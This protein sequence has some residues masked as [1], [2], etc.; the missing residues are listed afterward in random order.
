MSLHTLANH[1]QTAGRG[2]DKVLVHMTPGEVNGL[3]SLAMAHG[4]SLS[5]NPETGLPEAGFLSKILPMVAGLALGPAGAGIAFGGMSSAV[6]AG[7]LVGGATAL[8]TG[9]LKNGLLAGL[10]AYGGAGLGAGISGAAAAAPSL[11]GAGAA[12]PLTIAQQAGQGALAT[13][14]SGAATGAATSAGAGAG[15]AAGNFAGIPGT[16]AGAMYGAPIA[17]PSVAPPVAPYGSAPNLNAGVPQPTDL[18][19]LAQQRAFAQQAAQVPPS[20]AIEQAAKSK[21]IF[22]GMDFSKLMNPEFMKENKGNYLAAMAPLLMEE[23][24]RK[25]QSEQAAAPAYYG[26]SRVVNPSARAP[27]GTSERTYFADGGL[28]NLPVE[29]MSQQNTVGA[30]TNY[31]MANSKPYGYSVPK[32]NPISQNVFQPDG[33]QNVDPYTGEQKLANGGIIALKKGG[34]APAPAAPKSEAQINE[35]NAAKEYAAW[36]KDR[37]ADK[38]KAKAESDARIKELNKEYTDRIS[39]FGKDTGKELKERQ[40]AIK[41]EKDKAAKTEMQKELNAWQQGRNSELANLK[42]EQA[43]AIKDRTSEYTNRV[44][45]LDSEIKERQALRNFETDVFKKGYTGFSGD[46]KGDDLTALNKGYDTEIGKQKSE[47]EKAKQALEAAKKTGIQSLINR[48]QDT[49]NQQQGEYDEATKAKDS[50]ITQF[51]EE[52]KR[53]SGLQA[54]AFDASAPANTAAIEKKIKDIKA[55]PTDIGGGF[56]QRSLSQSQKDE[57]SSLEKELAGAKTGQVIDPATGKMVADKTP[58]SYQ[59][60]TKVPGLD[61]TVKILEE[62]DIRTVFEEMAGRAPT[63]SEMDKYLG[64]KT[65]QAALAKAL[66]DPKKG[67]AELQ[68]AQKFT[69]DDLNQQAVYYWGREMTPGELKYFKNPANKVSNFNVLRNMLTSDSKYLENLNKVN[70]AAFTSAQKAIQA[71][72]EGRASKKD[73]ASYYQQVF[74]KAPSPEEL[75]KF[76]NTGLN[77]SALKEQIDSSPAYEKTLTQSFVPGIVPSGSTTGS[78][79]PSIAQD[80]SPYVMPTLKQATPMLQD[81]PISQQTSGVYKYDPFAVTPKLTTENPTIPYADV[82]QKLGLIDLYSQLGQPSLTP[83]KTNYGVPTA[84]SGLTAPQQDIFG[85]SQY[86]PGVEQAIKAYAAQQAAQQAQAPTGMASGGIAGYNLGGYSDGGRLLKGPG[87]GVSDSIPASIGDRQ[88]ARL[89]DGEFVVPARIV[90][91]L[92]NG[93]TEAGARKLY[94]MMERVQRARGKS[95]GKGKVAVNSRAEKMLPA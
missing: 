86:P 3:Q 41:A 13:G 71:E 45:E 26:V 19:A 53:G 83:Q 8:G 11:A 91:E 50:R 30:N 73:I 47:A 48:A 72:T 23:E 24:R 78:L 62:K 34:K 90:S 28:A 80:V 7:L 36:V 68:A 66:T 55:N 94:A 61:G 29:N 16:N 27:G 35:E 38:A 40:A 49:Y 42:T 95:I 39:S 59:K 69:D 15:A 9:S 18:N 92:G 12:A 31:P 63:K 46:I 37:N 57:I 54:R 93:S 17:P 56:G 79:V 64:G 2:E 51:R 58:K 33:Y 21:G 1:L 75:D 65:S 44:K 4:G 76:Y 32:N 87:D 10:G 82:S 43:N 74:N 5:I 20:A 14:M 67:L 77:I 52:T 81:L 88:P 60:L 84:Q 6:S 89:A 85:F 70:Q 22:G 25:Q